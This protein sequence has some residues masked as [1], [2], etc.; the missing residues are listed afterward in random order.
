MREQL[1]AKTEVPGDVY[2]L[3]LV[4]ICYRFLGAEECET[5]AG[6]YVRGE[7]FADKGQIEFVFE[8]YGDFD[9]VAA[10]EFLVG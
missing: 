1:Y 6:E 10:T 5:W 9:V 8:V 2:A 7:Y 3:V 4:S